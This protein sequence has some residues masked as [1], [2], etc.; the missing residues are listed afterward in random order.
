MTL[1]DFC[2]Q[3]RLMSD[4]TVNPACSI[5]NP[6][7][8]IGQIIAIAYIVAIILSFFFIIL[9]GLRYIISGGDKDK[10][11]KA[12]ATIFNAIIGLAIVSLSIPALKL[13]G[14]ILGFDLGRLQLPFS[15]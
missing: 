15:S 8:L 6:Q 2:I 1:P 7:A 14:Q 13:I 12:R 3:T 10:T 11:A 4:G 5:N 9:G